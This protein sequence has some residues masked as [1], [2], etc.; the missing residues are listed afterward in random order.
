MNPVPGQPWAPRRAAS[1]RR[2]PGQDP[3]RRNPQLGAALLALRR[4]GPPDP[5]PAAAP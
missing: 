1:G 4:L 2:R 5:A 3:A